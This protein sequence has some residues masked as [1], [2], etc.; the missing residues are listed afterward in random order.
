MPIFG[1]GISK[2]KVNPNSDKSLG[3]AHSSVSHKNLNC[4]GWGATA[5]DGFPGLFALRLPLG[6]ASGV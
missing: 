3:F 1:A 2:K 5:L 4:V 6:E